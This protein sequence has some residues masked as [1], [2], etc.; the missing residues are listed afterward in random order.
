MEELVLDN[1]SAAVVVVVIVFVVMMSRCVSLWL[2]KSF[3][4]SL[5]H[6]KLYWKA[7][8]SRHC[9]AVG[10]VLF[11][12]ILHIFFKL[13]IHIGALDPGLLTQSIQKYPALVYACIGLVCCVCCFFMF[14]GACW[15][16][17]QFPEM[18]EIP[19]S[20]WGKPPVVPPPL[21]LFIL[22][23]CSLFDKCFC[24][25]DWRFLGCCNPFF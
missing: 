1:A 17:T 11:L 12:H 23:V 24:N 18:C 14:A 21:P 3:S 19:I 6:S 22:H 13:I 5:S 4:V 8:C 9:C 7:L 25:I 20:I 10:A 2:K 15:I 16:A